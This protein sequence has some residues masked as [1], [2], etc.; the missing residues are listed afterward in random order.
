MYCTYTHI[1]IYIYVDGICLRMCPFGLECRK[2]HQNQPICLCGSWP[3]TPG[4]VLAVWVWD[5]HSG[6][7]IIDISLTTTTNY[8]YHYSHYYHHYHY[9]VCVRSPCPVFRFVAEHGSNH[10]H[11]WAN[12]L[13][14]VHFPRIQPKRAHTQ[15]NTIHIS[16]YIYIYI[17]VYM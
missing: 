14:L 7:I 15:T 4:L 6:I 8:D 9:T 17:Y 16:I 5:S 3:D 1:Y 13:I 11:T 12:G 2:L 10:G